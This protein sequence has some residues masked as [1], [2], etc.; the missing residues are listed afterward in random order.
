MRNGNFT[1]S[2]TI[3][4]IFGKI[5]LSIQYSN[6][7]KRK[8]SFKSKH[9]ANLIIFIKI[10]SFKKKINRKVQLKLIIFILFSRSS[11]ALG[12]SVGHFLYQVVF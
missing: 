6:L 8:D 2:V 9:L 4:K 11:F 7:S 12:T 5:T 10:V 1:I 3:L